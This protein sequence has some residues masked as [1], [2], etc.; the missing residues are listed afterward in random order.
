MS[1]GF[2]SSYPLSILP[3]SYTFRLGFLR[4]DM[5]SDIQSQG[6]QWSS[7]IMVVDYTQQKSGGYYPP[8]WVENVCPKQYTYF[9]GNQTPVVFT[10]HS[11]GP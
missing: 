2:K 7:I 5:T 4:L 1:L 10:T 11:N 6:N 8:K 3:Y 9:G